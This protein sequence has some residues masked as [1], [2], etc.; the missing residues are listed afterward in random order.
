MTVGTVDRELAR[1]IIAAYM[2]AR[3]DLAAVLQQAFERLP[4]N[5]TPAQ[6]RG[7]LSQL[8]LLDGIDARLD[9]LARAL[10]D[11]L[12]DA[13]TDVTRLSVDDIAREVTRLAVQ[14]GL[15]VALP[16]LAIDPLLELTVA[17]VIEQIPGLMAALKAELRMTL[18]TSL[19]RGDRMEAISR[20]LYGRGKDR[21]AFQRHLTSARLMAHRA[22][23]EAENGAR[24]LW[25]ENAKQ[26]L[27]QLKKQARAKLDG[28]TSDVCEDVHEQVRELDEPFVLSGNGR[29]SSRKQTPPFHWGPCRTVI[30]GYLG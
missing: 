6:I 16:L 24:Q 25:L 21:G 19:A 8:S 5:P 18:R 23:S 13:L 9:E 30:T 12:T 2:K 15:D 1:E 14:A 26:N 22:V 10:D 3:N 11:L 4:A 17:P 20:A 27:P 7:L 29:L 28:K